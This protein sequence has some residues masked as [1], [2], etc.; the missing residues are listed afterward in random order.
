MSRWRDVHV[1]TTSKKWL[2]SWTRPG[3]C[4]PLLGAWWAIECCKNVGIGQ[5]ISFRKALTCL[6]PTKPSDFLP[7][8]WAPFLCIAHWLVGAWWVWC[9]FFVLK[10]LSTL[11]IYRTEGK[12]R[13]SPGLSKD[14]FALH[15]HTTFLT[16]PK[17]VLRWDQARTVPNSL[18][19]EKGA[20]LIASIKVGSFSVSKSFDWLIRTN[21]L[22]PIECFFGKVMSMCCF[23][24]GPGL[25]GHCGRD[26]WGYSGRDPRGRGWFVR[27][28]D[29]SSNFGQMY[30]MHITEKTTI[31]LDI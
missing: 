22:F 8:R 20:T 4:T 31:L 30:Y 3:K 17:R 5:R 27:M 15:L 21:H 12:P 2:L 11:W 19:S 13:L 14:L 9:D 6:W 23:G 29:V 26:V 1:R 24:P 25:C 28:H 10:L 16:R 7:G 18:V